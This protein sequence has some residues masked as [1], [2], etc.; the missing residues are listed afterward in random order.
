MRLVTDMARMLKMGGTLS[1][2]RA[3]EPSL[4]LAW[5]YTKGKLY[6]DLFIDSQLSLTYALSIL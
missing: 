3:P 6:R 2:L 5:Q 1:A 4:D